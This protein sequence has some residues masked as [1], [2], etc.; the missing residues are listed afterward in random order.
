[1]PET[2]LTPPNTSISTR[3]PTWP[4]E[5]CG[6]STAEKIVGSRSLLSAVMS[7]HYTK[8]MAKKSAAKILSEGPQKQGAQ[9]S[10]RQTAGRPGTAP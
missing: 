4:S 10:G 8:T 9:T 5:R 7:A 2:K 6:V 3:K 1:M